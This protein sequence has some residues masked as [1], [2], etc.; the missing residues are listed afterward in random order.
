MHVDKQWGLTESPYY[1]FDHHNGV[2]E[3]LSPEDWVEV[4]QQDVEMLPSVS[5]RY[6]DGH[7]VSCRTFDR[8]PR[9]PG[10]DTR[11]VRD[12]GLFGQVAVVVQIDVVGNASLYRKERHI[13][14]YM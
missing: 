14:M 3:L 10:Q 2:V 4:G 13:Y 7:T 8:T 6:D 5:V 12:D 9:P 1:L 11:I